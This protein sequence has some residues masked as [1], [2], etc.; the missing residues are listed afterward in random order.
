MLKRTHSQPAFIFLVA[1]CAGP[2]LSFTLSTWTPSSVR[3]PTFSKPQF[4]ALKDFDDVDE[5]QKEMK[6][7]TELSF[8]DGA[9][10][11]E[12]EERIVYLDKEITSR[13]VKL[14]ERSD[15]WSLEKS[16]LVAEVANLTNVINSEMN[17]AEN[18]DPSEREVD[19]EE[20]IQILKSSLEETQQALTEAKSIAE[21]IKS[22]L[23]D[24]EDQLEYEQMS[25][26]KQK[27]ELDMKI[28]EERMKLDQVTKDFEEEQNRFCGERDELIVK[29]DCAMFKIRDTETK[30]RN[31]NTKYREE[32]D[33]LLQKVEEL[34]RNLSQT[35]DLLK[36]ETAAYAKERRELDQEI[37]NQEVE[38]QENQR[39]LGKTEEEFQRTK[40]TLEQELAGEKNE[41]R[42]LTNRLEEVTEKFNQE[43]TD[44]KSQLENERAKLSEVQNQLE[45]DTKCFQKEKKDLESQISEGVINRRLKAKQM[46]KRYKTIRRQLTETLEGTKRDG[47]RRDN[48]LRNNYE[49]KLEDINQNVQKLENDLTGMTS[50]LQKVSDE[51]E[52]TQSERDSLVTKLHLT[53]RQS[54]QTISAR[55]LEITGLK[56]DVCFLEIATQEKSEKINKY[57]QSFRQLMKLSLILTKKRIKS[58]PSRLVKLVRR[59]KK[60][61]KD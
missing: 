51:L 36:T 16:S 2:A 11:G 1:I 55:N 49:T 38:L 22:R 39:V 32:T 31:E 35:S 46:N 23:L 12:L 13:E 33:S 9:N 48:Y 57:E 52:V 53:E 27:D 59:Q 20:E 34:K 10:V 40:R 25:F 30:M 15:A 47:R 7:V 42:Q 24:G 19:L 29:V 58:V 14:K 45:E 61:S 28:E 17:E 4:M 43:E 44:L 54:L 8:Q 56:Q 6:E 5:L 41:V 50:G 37:S 21:E 60:D 26:K 3:M 18:N